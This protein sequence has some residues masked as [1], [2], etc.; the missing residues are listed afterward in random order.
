[1]RVFFQKKIEIPF[2][3]AVPTRYLVSSIF[4]A[5]PCVCFHFKY[6][7]L[8]FNPRI[9]KINT[10]AINT[11]KLLKNI[12]KCRLNM[13]NALIF[14]FIIALLIGCGPVKYVYVKGDTVV[15]YRDSTIFRTDTL[16]VPVPVEKTVEITPTD[17][18]RMET[19]LA[20]SVSYYDKD[21]RMLRGSLENK[22]T[23]IPVKVEYKDRIITRDSIVVKEVPVEVQVEKVVKHVPWWAKFLSGIGFAA[24][25]YGIAR[26]LLWLK[27]KGII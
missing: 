9:T 18:L 17:T 19:S 5:C 7:N 4:N 11:G 15:E 10:D 24:L 23:T 20:K 27:G 21:I 26:L 6:T 1:M 3:G 25:A 8:F 14:A 22:K 16:E 12:T 2:G 13:K